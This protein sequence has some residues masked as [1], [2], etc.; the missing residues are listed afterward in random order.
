[1]PSFRQKFSG[2]FRQFSAPSESRND[3]NASNRFIKKN[4]INKHV[5]V[6]LHG[7]TPQ[8]VP[9]HALGQIINYEVIASLT[10]PNGGLQSVNQTEKNLSVSDPEINF[11]D[12]IDGECDEYNEEK[13]RSLSNNINT[14]EKNNSEVKLNILRKLKSHLVAGVENWNNPTSNAYGASCSLYEVHPITHRHT[15]D[16]I[17]D[18]FAIVTRAN[19]AI[20]VLADGVNW[21]VKSRTAARSAV[22]GCVDYLNK[23]LYPNTKQSP[24][25]TTDVLLT[26][27]RSFHAAHNM[28]LQEEGT[29]TTLTAVVV[30]PSVVDN[31]FIACCC[32][33]GDSLGYVYSPKYGVRELTQG[34][35]DIHR[36]RDMR[37]V[38]GALGPVDGHN[39]EL[40]NLTLSITQIDLGDIVF[41][42]S[43]GVSDN[44][45][46]VV[47][48]FTGLPNVEAYQRH[49]LSL[50][51]T[52]DLIR[53]GVSGK[54]PAVDTPK[55]L[56]T[57][58]LDFVTRL[59][60]AKRR[61]LED[62]EIYA[63]VNG[64]PLA[65]GEVR[66]KRKDIIKKSFGVPGKLDHATVVAYKVTSEV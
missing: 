52:E 19:S 51:R 34:S 59:T 23:T 4:E 49:K 58:L 45:D 33:V 12:N 48:H 7:R 13:K 55:E 20:M 43:D 31:Q 60:A 6:I 46:P 40:S 1:M 27:L 35:H 56:V 47:G 17:A 14:D 5:P 53:N 41:I 63:D 36:M 50:L 64:K 66:Q 65:Q 38:M 32:N 3:E 10:G 25:S 11:I 37:D 42:T 54:G 15:G 24:K 2:F 28:I 61:I 9:P 18:C 21:G 16:P 22:H 57:L 8:E 26:L 39:P 29:L 30:F 62:I 44:L